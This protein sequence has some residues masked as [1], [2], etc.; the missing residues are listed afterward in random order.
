MTIL[1]GFDVATMTLAYCIVEHHAHETDDDENIPF[2][3]PAI[4]S[5]STDNIS[6]GKPDKNIH[7]VERVARTVNYLNTKVDPELKRIL[8]DRPM[9][10]VIVLVE[11][12]M[13]PNTPARIVM[14]TIIARYA[15]KC[16]VI[17]VGPSLKNR[18]AL[19]K[20]LEYR[21]YVDRYKT[22]YCANKNHTTDNFIYALSVANESGQP[23]QKTKLIGHTADAFCQIVG[24]LQ[25]GCAE[26]AF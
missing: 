18:I 13:G 8:G 10:S 25:F 14:T 7:I 26:D 20:G 2:V 12:Q 11:N 16:R 22:L 1:I 6:G 15:D 17:I 19:N 3:L 5:F 9:E 23:P 21:N 24:Y 4:L